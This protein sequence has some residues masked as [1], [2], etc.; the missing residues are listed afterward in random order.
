MLSKNLKIKK[1]T[2]L[3]IVLSVLSFNIQAQSE[4]A[5]NITPEQQNIESE[6]STQVPLTTKTT[7]TKNKKSKNST[8]H[9]GMFKLLIPES[10]R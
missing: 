5:T 9:M 1:T 2:A 4:Q 6:T 8:D 10:L 3:C 7:H